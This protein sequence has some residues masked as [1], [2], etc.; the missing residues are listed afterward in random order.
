MQGIDPLMSID[1][2]VHSLDDPLVKSFCDAAK[3]ALRENG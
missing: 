3:L 1:I 2:A